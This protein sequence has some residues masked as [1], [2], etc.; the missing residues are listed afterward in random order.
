MRCQDC[1]KFVAFD[2]GNVDDVEVELD[3][4][5]GTVTI[6]G[7]VVLPCAEC[8]AELKELSVDETVE[9]ADEFNDVLA[10][11]TDAAPVGLKKTVTPEW[12]DKHVTV[13]YEFDGDP[14][15]EFHERAQTTVK[16][17]IKK[18][19]KVIGHKERKIK[20]A[21][22]MKTY[23]GV[24][25]SGTVKR[26]IEVADPEFPVTASDDTADFDHTVEEQSSA[27]EELT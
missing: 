4:D 21:R 18:K 7:R 22:Y 5:A 6:T 27:F 14:D 17:P 8:G 19:G 26:T 10:V 9:V 16:V 11:L 1:N 2:D 24:R 13:K 20:S 12:V 15:T 23:K 3:E 25:V